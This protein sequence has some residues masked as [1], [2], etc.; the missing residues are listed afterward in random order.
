MFQLG[1]FEVQSKFIKQIEKVQIKN[2]DILKSTISTITY[3]YKR[4]EK[5]SV[6]AAILRRAS[7]LVMLAK[8]VEAFREKPK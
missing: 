3:S 6:Q 7:P 2:D 8:T 5:P 1:K 4:F